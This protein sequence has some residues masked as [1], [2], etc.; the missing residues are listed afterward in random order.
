MRIVEQEGGGET[1]HAVGA[2]SVSWAPS[3]SPGGLWNSKSDATPVRRLV[4]GGC[5]NLVKVRDRGMRRSRDFV[6]IVYRK[7]LSLFFTV[8]LEVQ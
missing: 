6:L 8:D 4:T 7:T 1:T 5:D 2:N 3:V